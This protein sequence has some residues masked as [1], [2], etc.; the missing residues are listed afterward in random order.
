MLKGKYH[1][2]QYKIDRAS[3]LSQGPVIAVG[4]CHKELRRY[5]NSNKKITDP[6]MIEG[7]C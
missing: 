3:N 2:T 5:K 6:I 1:K 4:G 7:S